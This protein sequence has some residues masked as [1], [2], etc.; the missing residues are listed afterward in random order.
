VSPVGGTA[1]ISNDHLFL[2]V[3]GGSNHDVLAPGNQSVR[4]MQ[5]IGND[6]FDVAV[7]IDSTLAAVNEGTKEGLM[8][9][10]D[11]ADYICFELAAD[12]TNIHLSAETVAGGL[13]T[14][15]LDTTDFTQHQGSIYLRLSR[16]GSAYIAYYSVDGTNWTQATSFTAIKIPVSIGLFGSN[17]NASPTMANP[18]TMSVNWFHSE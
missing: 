4:V 15:V 17:Y 6:D 14:V 10:S 8:V 18:V 5:A 3:P 16:K 11:R 1:S 7:K 12:G 2:N 9:T 13:A